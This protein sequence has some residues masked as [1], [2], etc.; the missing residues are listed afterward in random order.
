M[1]W[2]GFPAGAD[3]GWWRVDTTIPPAIEPVTLAEA[4]A[5]ARVEYPDE[6]SLILDLIQACRE[7]V[8]ADLKR[9]L[10]TQTKTIFFQGFP[11]S[12]G[13]FNPQIRAMGPNPFW[14]PGGQGIINLPYPPVQS[15]GFEGTTV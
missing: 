7:R 14:L 12:G 15:I 10:I 4:K 11:T 8:E 9:A 1:S 2:P 3:P 6:D 5:W 13:Y